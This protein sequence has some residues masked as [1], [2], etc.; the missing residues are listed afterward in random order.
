M[1]ESIRKIQNS[2]TEYQRQGSNWTLDKVIQIQIHFAKYKPLK[3]SS[4]IPLPIK[5]RSKHAIINV[6]NKDKKCF[7]WSILAA[8]HPVKRDS[9]RVTKY[10]DHRHELNFDGISFPVKV[11]DINKFETQNK[12]TVNVLGYEKGSLF[13]IHVT[14]QRFDRHVDLL[15]I[16]DGRKSHY[17]WIKNVNGLLY[18]QY[19]YGH[20]Y[21]H[22]MYCLQGFTK[23]RIL[24]DHISYCREHRTQKVKL[25]TEE[26]KWLF[27]KDVRK[28]L[29]VPY[30]IYADF[31][32]FQVPIHRCEVDPNKSHTEKT[33]Q[34]VPSSFAYKVVGLTQ[35][36]S[37]EPLVYRGPDVTEKFVECMLR[38]QEDIEQKFKNVKPMVMTGRDW[39]AFKT[40]ISCHICGKEL[41]DDRVRDHCHVTGAFRGAAHNECNIMF[42]KFTGRIPVVFHNLRGYDSHL[43]MQAVGKVSDK[44]IKCI[45]NNMEKYI[46]FSIGCMDFIDSFQFMGTSLEKL[47]ANLSE[48]GKDT[49]EHMTQ[50]FGEEKIEHLLKKQVYPYD[51]FD[52]PHRFQ[53]TVLPPK[54]AFRSSLTG[55]DVSDEKYDHALKVWKQLGIHNLGE[56]SDLYVITDVLG[57]ADV[58]E[59]FRN[60]CLESYGLDA[61]HFYTAPGLAW[62]A[63]LKMTDVRLE[64]L[65]DIDQHLFIE[66]GL[67][68]GI[69]MISHR[70]AEANN[71]YVPGYDKTK[72]TDYITY[73]DANNLYGWAMSQCLPTHDFAWLTDTAKYTLDITTVPDDAIDGYILEVD[74]EY[75]PELHDL[76]NEYPLAP[77]R[78]AVGKDEL[79]DYSQTLWRKLADCGKPHDDEKPHDC[80]D[81]YNSAQK[82]VPN[83][84]NKEKYV[85][86]YRNLKQY[87]SFG[88]KL[89]KVHRVLTF[90]Q[91]PWLKTYIDYNTEKRKQSRNCI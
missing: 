11:A 8:L 47:I 83:L 49:F 81:H 46:S 82:L 89:T 70:F 13:P 21:Y 44:E 29:K 84:R 68:G 87:F 52:G 38:E 90:K 34:H 37:K 69:S 91:S 42:F 85:L 56:Y 57:L 12:I 33:T 65:T 10:I 4:Y 88:M 30:I 76:H 73:L 61:A 16:T 1:R 7:M 75:P 67:R 36:T 3:G 14:K 32:S 25:P 26:D 48:E 79:S 77:E 17:C 66:K 62:Q 6:Q 40:A 43:I 50:H 5:L 80:L 23:G 71:P 18:D 39:Q 2:F 64:L 45:P 60:L 86:H 19:S 72:P 63:A 41:G 15:L 27:Y 78:V 24:N 51:Y 58:F 55:E 28:Q 20:R 9:Q 54:E 53:E 74:L 35:T 31:E 22:C 59:N